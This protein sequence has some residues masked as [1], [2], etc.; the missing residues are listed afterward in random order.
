MEEVVSARRKER[1]DQ[2]RKH[3]EEVVASDP[4]HREYDVIMAE[5]RAEQES[6]DAFRRAHSCHPG[7]FLERSKLPPTHPPDA[8]LEFFV[9][10]A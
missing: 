10:C 2:E 9:A 5:K 7:T 1:Q 3:R 6:L 4:R 8:M